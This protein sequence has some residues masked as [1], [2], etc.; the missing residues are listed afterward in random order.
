MSRR[1]NGH[2]G[3]SEEAYQLNCAIPTRYTALMRRLMDASKRGVETSA[4][5]CAEVG[6][7]QYQTRIHEGR[8]KGWPILNRLEKSGGQVLSYYRIDFNALRKTGR[9]DLLALALPDEHPLSVPISAPLSR[10][11][12]TLPLFGDGGH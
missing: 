6:G 12:E 10:P 11:D 4:S 1:R 7:L 2:S 8:K 9:S 5:E 3:N